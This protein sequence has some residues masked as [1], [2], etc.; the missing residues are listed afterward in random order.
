M[1]SSQAS[2]A[3]IIDH[4]IKIIIIHEKPLKLNPNI[5]G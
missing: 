2:S 3:L 1:I 4:I 5:L